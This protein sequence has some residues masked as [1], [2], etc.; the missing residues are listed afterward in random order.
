M[1]GA[2]FTVDSDMHE[3]GDDGA[4]DNDDDGGFAAG[5]A[6]VTGAG[7]TRENESLETSFV[8]CFSLPAMGLDCGFV[9]GG[10]FPGL[11]GVSLLELVTLCRLEASIGSR[12]SV[13]LGDIIAGDGDEVLGLGEIESRIS[14]ELCR[15]GIA[16][17]TRS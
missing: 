3:E 11:A 2:L 8:V 17:D 13:A 4:D 12:R 6:G 7:P 14:E 15:P 9:N 1:L 5:V 10:R 16:Y